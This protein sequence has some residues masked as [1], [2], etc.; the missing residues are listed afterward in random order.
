MVR[1]S[2]H[3]ACETPRPRHRPLAGAGAG[4][5]EGRTMAS[6]RSP[7]TQAKRAREQAV[8][9]KRERKAAKKQ[10]AIL[11]RNEPAVEIA[12]DA[13]G[14]EGVESSGSSDDAHGGDESPVAE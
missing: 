11:A 8:R 5:S 4:I 7:Q 1:H 6:K 2:P 12:E 10:A 13:E 3:R 14:A 9:E